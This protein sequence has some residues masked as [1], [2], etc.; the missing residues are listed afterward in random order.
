MEADT[1]ADMTARIPVIEKRHCLSL[2]ANLF[3]LRLSYMP[4]HVLFSIPEME[5][6]TE[7]LPC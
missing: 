6:D 5:Q 4:A 1:E 3:L 7:I 2:F